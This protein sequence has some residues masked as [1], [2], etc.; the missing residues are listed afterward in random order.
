MSGTRNRTH[1][2]QSTRASASHGDDRGAKLGEHAPGHA[3]AEPGEV[4]RF[5]DRASELMR[6]LL[7]ELARAPGRPRP[8]PEVEEAIGWPR[9]RIAAVLGGAGRARIEEFG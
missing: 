3:M 2:S 4:A 1:S 8:F 9:R 7:D 6:T 5:Y